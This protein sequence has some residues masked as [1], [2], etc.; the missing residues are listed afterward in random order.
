M[1]PP[2]LFANGPYKKSKSRRDAKICPNCKS[3]IIN[4]PVEPIV[5]LTKLKFKPEYWEYSDY[6]HFLNAAENKVLKKK[7]NM[8]MPWQTDHL[9]PAGHICIGSSHGW[10]AYI[11]RNNC[12]L[13][14]YNPF[15]ESSSMAYL[16]LPP[17]ETLPPIIS[18]RRRLNIDSTSS[19]SSIVTE[20]MIW[21]HMSLVSALD[22]SHNFF[23]KVVMSSA[24]SPF[25]ADQDSRCTVM[26]I[27]G[28]EDPQRLAFCRIGDTSWTALN[29]PLTDSY[30]DL[31][32]FSKTQLFYALTHNGYVE[33]WNLSDPSSP[34]RSLAISTMPPKLQPTM[35][36]HQQSVRSHDYAHTTMYLAE[37][38][39]ELVMV[40]RHKCFN[41]GVFP[42]S[43][44]AKENT[45]AFDVYKL[46]FV[47]NKWVYVPSLCD[48]LLFIGQNHSVSLS[49]N[50]FPGLR[51]N[52][53]YF[54]PENVGSD[55]DGAPEG[56]NDLGVF[57]LEDDSL[58][59]LD[60]EYME[61]S[62]I[63]VV[64]QI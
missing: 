55:S 57:N 23:R 52:S 3:T 5:R 2:C 51:K 29:S 27:Y 15:I 22:V 43:V 25:G 13:Y 58:Q 19:S 14:L 59:R 11:L 54:A 38:S 62:P 48:R 46:D 6:H 30:V 16:P 45:A 20:F 1:V 37:S 17:I 35:N 24:P 4:E 42:F 12:S 50:D 44:V 61:P 47:E 26:A 64:P 63:W 41:R 33:S 39:E 18:S 7:I 32:Y 60:L 56:C 34:E 21:K 28:Q 31:L 9:P 10:L 53:I 49:A 8:W 36:N 40:L